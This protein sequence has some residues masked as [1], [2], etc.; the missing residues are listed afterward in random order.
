VT[1]E[2]PPQMTGRFLS[3]ILVPNRDAVEAEKKK[4]AQ[5]DA[6]REAERSEGGVGGA[7]A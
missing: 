2:N 5:E 7:D 1:V 3:M 6:A 4:A